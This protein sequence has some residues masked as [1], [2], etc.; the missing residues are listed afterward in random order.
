M[1]SDQSQNE[2]NNSD[3]ADI[4]E[5]KILLPVE[6]E[7]FAQFIS[8]L[9]GKPQT[10]RKFYAGQFAL[11]YDDVIN[12]SQLIEQRMHHQNDA[13][14]IQFLV[15]INYNDDSSVQ[16]NSIEAFKHY[17]EIKPLVCVGVTLS[18]IYLVKFPQKDAPEKQQIDLSFDVKG[19]FSRPIVTSADEH[20]Q[21]LRVGAGTIRLEIRHTERTWG[22]DIESL[23]DGH[24]QRIIQAP[25]G[26]KNW[27]SEHSDSIG[28]AL[29]LI[30]FFGAIAGSAVTT[31]NFIDSH[32]L[33]YTDKFVNLS[34]DLKSLNTRVE[35]LVN[36][37]LSGVWPRFLLM[38]VSFVSAS[39]V[40]AIFLGMWVSNKANNKPP[41][42]ILLSEESKI[43]KGKHENK[44]KRDWRMFCVSVI[45][46]IFVGILSNILFHNYFSTI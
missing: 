8:G 12:T 22:N 30:I 13:S 10:S 15:S 38:L 4:I 11:T 20:W 31:A 5:A 29:G 35:Y 42:F 21:I 41:S 26:I 3:A 33:T 39:I 43:M 23:L 27:I 37:S 46:S 16:V 44:I 25:K 18:W 36:I 28:L 14:L 40:V 6:P 32:L 24:I 2:S 17:T 9:L 34:G 19:H 1:E 7:H 45:T